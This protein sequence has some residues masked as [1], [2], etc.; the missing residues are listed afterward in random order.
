MR[1]DSLRTLAKFAALWFGPADLKTI[2]LCTLL[3]IV[4]TSL[5]RALADEWL[6]EQ[7]HCALTIPT[8]ES[9]TAGL[10]PQLP[11]GE[12]LLNAA[13]MTSNQGIML[14]YVEE[15]PSAD[16]KNPALIKR[17]IEVVESLGWQTESSSP[18]DWKGRKCIQFI[19]Q[20]KDIVAGRQI[21][22]AR[23][24]MRGKSLYLVTAYGKGEA[25]RADSP[26]FM[27]VVETFRFV[28]QP[29]PI[30][31]DSAKPPA[32]FFKVAM[33]GTAAAAAM[34]MLVYAAMLIISLRAA[35]EHA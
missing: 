32:I 1:A 27:R 31:I 15:M 25:N 9:W 17:I 14:T 19:M 4:T 29:Q 8:Q 35:K 33:L 30:Q 28:E 12:V 18:L 22:I 21:G 20:R 2:L 34:L 10:R 16:L 13:S 5:P 7:Y 26:E 24:L 6:S 23:A 3:L 11:L